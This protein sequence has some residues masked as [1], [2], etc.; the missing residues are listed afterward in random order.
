M[1]QNF[2]KI[3]PWLLLIVF[4]EQLALFCSKEFAG[5]RHWCFLIFCMLGYALVGLVVTLALKYQKNNI[6]VLN[7]LW[8]ICSTIFAFAL[9]ILLF[10]EPN[11]NPKRVL[12]VVVG[13]F[14]LVLAA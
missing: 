13:V 3:L 7:N 1:F 4:V 6:G 12:A 5:G 2:L 10:S 11:W 9:G 8:N 14:V